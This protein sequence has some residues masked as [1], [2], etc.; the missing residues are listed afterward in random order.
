MELRQGKFWGVA[1]D[2]HACGV[3]LPGGMP[4][5]G[6]YAARFDRVFYTK[7][8]A[9]GWGTFCHEIKENATERNGM[10]RNEMT[11]N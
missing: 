8:T 10:E 11:W 5:V 9:S 3:Q 6:P 4:W 7:V 1:H 2:L